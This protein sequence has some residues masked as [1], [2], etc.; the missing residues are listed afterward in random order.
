MCLFWLC[1]QVKS[2][3]DASEKRTNV[4]FWMPA[5]FLP[6]LLAATTVCI[7]Y[8][9]RLHSSLIQKQMYTKKFRQIRQR[10]KNVLNLAWFKNEFMRLHSTRKMS[11]Y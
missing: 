8:L 5:Q 11:W 7:L 2:Q 3:T 9:L 10:Y 1:V 6:D 4:P